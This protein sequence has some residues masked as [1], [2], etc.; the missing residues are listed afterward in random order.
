M[1]PFLG[2]IKKG[3]L[4]LILLLAAPLG[5]LSATTPILYFEVVPS[6]SI[7]VG[8]AIDVKIRLDSVDNDLNAYDI[9]FLYQPRF[10]TVVK[11][12][13]SYSLVDQWQNQPSIFA[14][15]ENNLVR[16]R[17]SSSNS[18]RGQGGELLT[19]RFLPIQEGVTALRFHNALVSLAD[20]SGAKISP[21]YGPFNTTITS[22]GSGSGSIPQG[23]PTGGQPPSSQSSGG[24]PASSDNSYSVST[25][26]PG[27]ESPSFIQNP[28]EPSKK[29]LTFSVSSEGSR[30]KE[31]TARS[32]AF[33]TWS[34]W[35]PVQD[36]QPFPDN[37]WAVE[38][39]AVDEEGSSVQKVVYDWRALGKSPFVPLLIGII[40]V[41]AAGY[42]Y[43]RF[44]AK[45]EI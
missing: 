5:V 21:Q 19:I 39:K 26:L 27:I 30:V 2:S 42:I 11:L 43:M 17:G 14:D 7:I 32:R 45:G 44:R 3:A 33:L 31:V 4:L 15:E 37:V 36:L 1:L 22:L 40:A 28:S 34:D 20:G 12:D 38:L 6:S 9:E 13:T 16:L 41:I 10:F 35:Q 23:Q 18:F 8:S 29:L 24:S 25:T